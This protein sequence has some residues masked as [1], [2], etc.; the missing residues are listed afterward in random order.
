MV[1]LSF[2]EFGKNEENSVETSVT[3]FA[4]VCVVEVKNT[5]SVILKLFDQVCTVLIIHLS[6]YCYYQVL[7]DIH[8]AMITFVRSRSRVWL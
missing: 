4:N 7:G 2:L 8:E 5:F 1:D 3:H 6:L